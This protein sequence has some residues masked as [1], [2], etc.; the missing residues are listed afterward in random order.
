MD[1]HL[2]PIKLYSRRPSPFIGLV[3]VFVGLVL[4]LLIGPLRTVPAGHVVVEH[5]GRSGQGTSSAR[6]LRN[7]CRPASG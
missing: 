5:C 7:R 1:R 3:L 4:L 2:D 6:S